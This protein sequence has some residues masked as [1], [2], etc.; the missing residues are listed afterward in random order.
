MR[1]DTLTFAPET[2]HQR[3]PRALPTLLATLALGCAALALAGCGGGG[4]G[5]AEP[6]QPPVTSTLPAPENFE[7]SGALSFAWSA[8]PGATRY[9]LFADLDGPGPKTEVQM[10]EAQGLSFYSTTQ[11]QF[12]YLNLARI[13]DF[14]NANFRLRA[15][16]SD[17]CGA[18]TAAKALDLPSRISYEFSSG[19]APLKSSSGNFDPIS[20]DGLTLVLR[21]SNGS[22]STLLVFTRTA[23]G[24]PWQQQA[25]I[26]TSAYRIALSADGNTL[27]ASEESKVQIYQRSSGTW[28]QPTTISSTQA[29]TACAQ[30][31]QLEPDRL[32]LSANGN[33]LAVSGRFRV[34]SSTAAAPSTVFTYVRT[35]TTWAA[36]NHFAPEGDIVG[37]ALALSGDGSTLALNSGAITRSVNI[38]P[39]L[40]RIYAQNVVDG[41]T[42]QAR[43]PVGIVYFI[44]IA[45]SVFSAMTLSHDGN[46]LAVEARNSPNT[47]PPEYHI[48]AADLTCPRA[49]TGNAAPVSHI[50]LFARSGAAWQR[51]AA[52]AREAAP[53]W[54]LANDGDALF[55]GELFNRRNGAWTC[56]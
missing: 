40:V 53:S 55:Y 43:L 10:G 31:C 26:P 36:Q 21:G 12:G 2:V 48:T 20:Q 52:I 45:A 35:G 13:P 50:A 4:S 1:H 25:E 56:P 27:A 9:E 47:L 18:F 22:T 8:T 19:R 38:T 44:D 30:P 5:S 41:W 7:N 3:A 32:A 34:T 37:T 17:G 16:N 23:A 54:A 33:V 15:C 39:P 24:Q 14:I 6:G 51:Q 46:T 11:R 28:S 42:E 49:G 29:P